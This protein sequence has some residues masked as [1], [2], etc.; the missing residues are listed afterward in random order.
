MPQ[1]FES[2]VRNKGR[3]RTIVPKKGTYVKVCYINGKSYSGEVHHTKR[4][5]DAIKESK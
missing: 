5:A 4:T 3:V 2:C 1:A